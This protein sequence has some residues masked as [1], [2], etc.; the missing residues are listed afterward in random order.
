MDRS[1]CPDGFNVYVSWDGRYV[2]N[3]VGHFAH[4]YGSWMSIDWTSG[5]GGDYSKDGTPPQLTVNWVWVHGAG[6]DT[7]ATFAC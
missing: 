7:S 5:V 6:G 2:A 1:G 3:A 4:P